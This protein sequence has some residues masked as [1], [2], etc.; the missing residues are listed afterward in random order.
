MEDNRLV[1]NI[2]YAFTG[3]F[4]LAVF[5]FFA[6]FYNNH[7]HFKEQTQLFLFSGDYF[8]SRIRLPGGFSGYTGSLLTQ[9]Y[10]WSFAGPLIIVLLL[11]GI[12]QLTLK[13]LRKL[14]SNPSFFPVSFLLP[15]NGA[16]VLCDE[17]YPLS[18]IAG[19]LLALLAASIY[20]KVRD[21]NRRFYYGILLLVITYWLGGGSFFMLLAI[22]VMYEILMALKS[23]RVKEANEKAAFKRL[24][25]WQLVLFVVIALGIPLLVQR[26]LVQQPL[27]LSYISEFYYDL[28]ITVPKAIPVLF[29]L[30]A[31]LMLVVFFLP[32]KIRKYTIALYAQIILMIPLTYGGLKLWAN[33]GAEDIMKYD[34]LV[35]MEEW[36]DVVKFADKKPPRNNLSLS[37]LNL[38]LAKTGRMGDLMFKYEQNG[39]D[40][41]FL[42]FT[43]EYVLPM[44]GSEI[45]YHLGLINASQEYSFESM[46]T[47]PNLGKS[48]RSI[49]RLAETN[50]INGQYEVAGKYLG[51]LKKT[52]FY[53]SWAKETEKY[54]NH[55]DLINN[56]PVYGEMRKSMI[57]KDFFFKVENMEAIL[58]MLMQEN[59]NNNTAFQYLMSFYLLN[60][61]LRNFM[62]CVP[63]MEKLGYT[64]IP[65]AYEE[66]IMYVV[67]LTTD[68]P[69]ANTDFRIS[70]KTKL[71]MQSYAQVYTSR[72]DAQDILR[73]KYS[74]TYWYYHHYKQVAIGSSNE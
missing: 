57:K 56:H 50:L 73:V 22:M 1:R 45:F 30:P 11:F 10:Y 40:G 62:R 7:L 2:E 60:K 63:M 55:E 34:H 66:A 61:D 23:K 3:L 36:D 32:S 52:L 6:F 72:R 15:L 69:M 46:E 16:L 71:R 33:F 17:F 53:R 27:G 58:N 54:L 18:G 20:I 68:N 8:T 42:P 44:M 38:S 19:L 67:G 29:A 41:L 31:F 14:N 39:F 21:N 12:Q 37:M 48:V 49:K 25:L 59:P 65:V 4:F 47:T 51:L 70:D 43:R 35:R 24:K 9:F 74:D 28:R 5:I 64:R 13:I 26:F